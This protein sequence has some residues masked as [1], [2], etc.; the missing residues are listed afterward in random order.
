MRFW[1]IQ[2]DGAG[3]LDRSRGTS[4]SRARVF[5]CEG[6]QV[7]APIEV[8]RLVRAEL[9]RVAE[10]D[11][12]ERIDVIYEQ[13]GTELTARRGNWT[14]PAWDPAGHGEHSVEAHRLAL[15]HYLDGGGIA[16]GAFS[17]GRLVG[18]GVVVSH[19]RPQIAQLA[20]LHVS[21]AFRAT[22]IGRRL[23]D[24]L[25]LIARDAGNSAI[26]VSATPSENTVRFYLSRGYE[27]TAQAL[28]ELYEAE[29]E[30]VHK[31]KAL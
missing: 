10:I 31:R 30:D 24:E 12:T 23:C 1:P 17:N 29:P 8:R 14:A 3:S 15:E 25:D 9:S 18:I 28:P 5:V 4:Q 20:F 16:L 2:F 27:L 19:L 7:G 26:V 6:G 11:R 21:Q 22:G 13:R